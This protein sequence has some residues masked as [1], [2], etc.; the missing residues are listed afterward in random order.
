MASAIGAAREAYAQHSRAKKK[1]AVQI[2]KRRLEWP[3]FDYC[4]IIFLTSASTRES[5]QF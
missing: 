5:T 4:C 1:K 2:Q 3:P